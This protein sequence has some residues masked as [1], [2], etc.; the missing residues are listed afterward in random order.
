[1]KSKIIKSLAMGSFVGSFIILLLMSIIS[2]RYGPQNI[3][4][5][6]TT[7]INAFLGTN[8]VGW[9]FSLSSLIYEKEEYPLPLQVIFQMFFGLTVL[10]IVA[11]YLQ[12]MPINLGIEP[13]ISWIVI[14]LI[15]A[16]VFWLGFYAYYKLLAREINK[17]LKLNNLK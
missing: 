8:I 1:M 10:Y 14:S 7:V 15:F 17:K 9:A 16:A 4:F 13:I 2:L 5:D 11:I 12:W 6:G 3:S